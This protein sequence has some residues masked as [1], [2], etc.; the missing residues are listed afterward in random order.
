MPITSGDA[1][2]QRRAID[3]WRKGCEALIKASSN[4]TDFSLANLPDARY[5]ADDYTY[6]HASTEWRKVM[7]AIA[8]QMKK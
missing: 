6:R 2:S 4:L 8:N 1:Y 7:E 5:F 3:E